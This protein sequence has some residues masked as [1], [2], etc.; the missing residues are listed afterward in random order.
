[1]KKDAEAHAEEDRKQKEKIETKN[2]A[3]AL[4]YSTEK[5]LK[6]HGDKVDETTRKSIEDALAELRK[7]LEGDD[8]EAIRR[9]EEKLAEASRK[10]G[11]VVYQQA[12]QQA[13]SAGGESSAGPEAGGGSASG[14]DDAEVVDAEVVDDKK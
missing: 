13:G 11:E 4:A 8:V 1:M 3:D 10:L 5:A 7:T 14:D 12:Q 2:R 9:A 6:E